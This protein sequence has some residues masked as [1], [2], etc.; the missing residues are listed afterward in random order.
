MQFDTRR[1]TRF[2]RRAAA[3]C[4]WWRAAGADNGTASAAAAASSGWPA[5]TTSSAARA[6]ACI[7]IASR[8]H[9]NQ[10]SEKLMKENNLD[11]TDIAKLH[12]QELKKMIDKSKELTP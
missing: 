7:E 2:L 10:F 5:A 4:A 12:L 1:Q 6:P 3:A 9:P 8:F 11:K